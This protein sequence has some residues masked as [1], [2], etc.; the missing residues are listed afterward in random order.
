MQSPPSSPLRNS[1]RSDAEVLLGWM[2]QLDDVMAK[3]EQ[4][5]NDMIDYGKDLP[6]PDLDFPFPPPP[7]LQ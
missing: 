6:F 2:K 1:I 3:T 7:P 5:M 4:E